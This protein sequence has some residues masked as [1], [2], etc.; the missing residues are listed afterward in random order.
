MNVIT[1]QPATNIKTTSQIEGT[2]EVE[3]KPQPEQVQKQN[4]SVEKKEKEESSKELQEVAESLNEYMDDFQ[5]QLGFFI[6]EDLDNE[7]IVEIKNRKTDELVKQIPSEEIVA[8][9]E[10]MAELTGLLFDKSV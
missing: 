10:K 6:N 8:I 4:E 7:V 9:R 1:I 5:T 3:L 2:K